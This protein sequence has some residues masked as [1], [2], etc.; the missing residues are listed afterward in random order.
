MRE[1]LMKQFFFATITAAA[2]SL[3]A[4]GGGGGGGG[5]TPVINQTS[6]SP[7]P[8]PTQAP[9]TTN[10]SG[11]VVDDGTG[12]PLVGVR[13]VLLPW[14]PCSA[15]PAPATI[16]P[17]TD[18]CP[19]PLPSPQATSDASGHFALNGVA[20]GHYEL[21]LGADS[22]ATTG[23]VLATVHDNVTLSGGNQVLVAP[24]MPAL[25]TVT[26]KAWEA[27]G[28]YRI[29]TLDP[30]T[31]VPCLQAW[32]AERQTNGLAIG[33]A[34][35]WLIENTRDINMARSSG[36]VPVNPVT[37]NGDHT[38]TGSETSDDGGSSCAGALVDPAIFGGGV[39][40]PTDPRTLWF[41][42]QY[43][44]YPV[45]G[46]PAQNIGVAEFPTDPRSYTDPF[47]PIWL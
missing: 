26:A 12:A 40:A 3:A 15:T 44:Q 33:T 10:A 7:T 36:G 21:V 4:C 17:E 8:S 32:D 29:A 25:P 13:A 1:F 35:E 9:L 31:E 11:T 38:L 2:I 14:G 18:G 19:T 30:T 43:G 45:P 6:A 27:N 22:T 46:G 28:D 34:D 20:N 5:V 47:V 41:G 23:T 16:T 37:I 42:G 39:Q 24:T